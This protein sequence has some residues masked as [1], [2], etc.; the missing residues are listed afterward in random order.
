MTIRYGYTALGHLD[1]RLAAGLR[2]GFDLIAA[3]SIAEPGSPCSP[4]SGHIRPQIQFL[5]YVA[6]I[7]PG[8]RSPLRCSPS[9]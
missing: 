4:L 6:A 7:C 2:R 1:A 3:P 5:Q 8:F 9:R